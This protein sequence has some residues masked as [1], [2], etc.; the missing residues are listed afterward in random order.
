MYH[1]WFVTS[2]SQ[3]L[4]VYPIKVREVAALDQVNTGLANQVWV[5]QREM[6][7]M[8]RHWRTRVQHHCSRRHK[9]RSGSWPLVPVGQCVHC[10]AQRLVWHL[11][12]CD[13]A[14]KEVSAHQM[15]FGK[16]D[17]ERAQSMSNC[18]E[19]HFLLYLII[20]SLF[21]LFVSNFFFSSFHR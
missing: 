16:C 19:Y 9:L 21:S 18:E 15:E 2:G 14:A 10:L 5:K 13:I 7:N 4:S 1:T 12:Q 20:T 6:E 11:M 17:I 8:Q 3:S